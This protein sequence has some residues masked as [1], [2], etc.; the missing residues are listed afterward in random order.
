MRLVRKSLSIKR[1]SNREFIL[2]KLRGNP[3]SYDSLKEL[4]QERMSYQ[5]F[6][7]WY[8]ILIEE[9]EIEKPL[10][11]LSKDYDT[12]N[13]FNVANIINAI[14][15]ETNKVLLT[16]RLIQLLGESSKKIAQFPGVMNTL[17][18]CL[19]N[20]TVIESKNIIETL[21]GVFYNIF[22]SEFKYPISTSKRILEE[23]TT[24]VIPTINQIISKKSEFPSGNL[25]RLLSVCGNNES[26][27]I[28]FSKMDI[29]SE[30]DASSRVT[31]N[32]G[33]FLGP[34]TRLYQNQL[35][36]IN[37]EL[38]DLARSENPKLQKISLD[39]RMNITQ[40][41]PFIL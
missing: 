23:L 27:K 8:N 33:H 32:L 22:V 29:Y 1:G 15:N 2:E 30:L 25:L 41:T 16:G 5:T 20:N 14:Q 19:D 13:P 10:L 38:D 17:L 12:A 26:A 18:G 9:K 24:I 36:Q 37:A 28:I 6:R 4:A 34:T 11:R 40:T 39:L 7:R 21:Y 35:E 31:I 3:L